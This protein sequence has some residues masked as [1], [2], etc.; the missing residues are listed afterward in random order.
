M[1]TR[2]FFWP[3]NWS[4]H[5]S[6]D[7]NYE[8]L[9]SNSGVSNDFY[10]REWKETSRHLDPSDTKSDFPQENSLPGLNSYRSADD[11]Y[12]NRYDLPPPPPPPPARKLSSA[13]ASHSPVSVGPNSNNHSSLYDP[14]TASSTNHDKYTLDVHSTSPSKLRSERLNPRKREYDQRDSSEESEAPGRRQADD[15]TPKHKKRQPKVAE[16][17]R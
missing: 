9:G 16:A 15:V 13:D 10:S 3:W 7:S 11:F 2:K 4:H 17:Y 8:N 1:S 12:P 14:N 5:F 6:Y